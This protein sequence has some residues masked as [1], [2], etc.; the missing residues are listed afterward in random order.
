M[1][2]A[3]AT[4]RPFSACQTDVQSIHPAAKRRKF[5]L[6]V[7]VEVGADEHIPIQEVFPDGTFT[8]ANDSHFERTSAA[9]SAFVARTL[10]APPPLP[11]TTRLNHASAS[12]HSRVFDSNQ[13]AQWPVTALAQV[14]G[15]IWELGRSLIVVDALRSETPLLRLTHTAPITRSN[16][17]IVQDG[18]ALVMAKR[19]SMVKCAEDISVRVKALVKW[20]RSDNEFCDSFLALRRRC[21]GVRRTP[22]GTPFIDVG[23]SE[24]VS[25]RRPPEAHLDIEAVG[26]ASTFDEP[27]VTRAC[28]LINYPA[29][30]FLKFCLQNV[31]NSES[32]T[33]APVV[34]DPSDSDD[35]SVVSAIRKIRMARVSSFRRNAFEVLAKQ[36][37]S[38][39]S[40]T[41]MSATH[42]T[43]DSGPCDLLSVE[44][45][46]QAQ[47]AV[48]L[49]F[50]LSRL[51]KEK[52]LQ[53]QLASILQIVVMQGALKH[54]FSQEPSMA[55]SHPGRPVLES[56]LNISIPRALL[57]RLDSVLNSAVEMLNVRLEW[58]RGASRAEE[59][60]VRI[61]STSADGDGEERLLAT[62]EPISNMNNCGNVKHNGYVRI[63][64]AF[65]VIMP[66]PNDPSVR[67][68]LVTTHSTSSS[69]GGSG[70]GLDDV[71]RA[72]I[73][74][75]GGEILSA[76]TL[77][78]CIR[79]L[80]SLETVAR[81]GIS[82]ILDVDRQCFAVIV[83]LP[84]RG[85][86]IM[87]KVW[88]HGDSLG[89]EIPNVQVWFN[90]QRI[91]ALSEPGRGRLETWKK[92]LEAA[93]KN[94]GADDKKLLSSAS[95][96]KGMSLIDTSNSFT[97]HGNLGTGT[98][99]EVEGR[100][101]VVNDVVQNGHSQVGVDLTPM[102]SSQY[103]AMLG[104]RD[105][106]TRKQ[107]T[108]PFRYGL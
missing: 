57:T 45:T 34:R 107:S 70:V 104:S 90:G 67:G 77:L 27:R 52:V 56:L 76:L 92:L 33:F 55:V 51:S 47:N 63:I 82:E 20:L 54:Q 8:H 40:I 79:L 80:D 65:G 62:I 78:L 28:L 38:L 89:H 23:D 14:E 30:V 16:E 4:S 48:S 43:V 96:E 25:V 74:P 46:Y 42:V 1:N 50:D 24:F 68:R 37:T 98:M 94:G 105:S 108:P 71:P 6:R 103:S 11:S 84:A 73:C 5:E 3:N 31:E 26:D 22:D 88:P 13:P 72:Y 21:H 99:N 87:A 18:A 36:A 83:L 75:V 7:S 58:T 59:T 10:A 15:A 35:H 100:I 93:V 32:S 19:R 53:V 66:A 17:N 9:A 95:P 91:D 44:H 86:S 106:G 12:T 29:P 97:R 69:S 85:D 81:A 64:P 101:S 60:R 39:S 2:D 102:L 61:Y 41:D 49:D